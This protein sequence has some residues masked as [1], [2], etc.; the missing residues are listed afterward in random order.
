MGCQNVSFD[1]QNVG[2]DCQNGGLPL[3]RKNVGCNSAR[4]DSAEGVKI[5]GRDGGREG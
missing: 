3:L 2:S 5:E 1:C 4:S